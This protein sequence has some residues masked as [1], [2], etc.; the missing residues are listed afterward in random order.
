MKIR[1]QIKNLALSELG[2]LNDLAEEPY[3]FRDEAARER[4]KEQILLS[5]ANDDGAVLDELIE[6]GFR[7]ADRVMTSASAET[8]KARIVGQGELLPYN[9]SQPLVLGE[10]ER[11]PFG[12]ARYEHLQRNLRVETENNIAQNAAFKEKYQVRTQFSDALRTLDPRTRVEDIV[13]I[14]GEDA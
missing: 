2:I 12:K 13:E 14:E 8:L 6:A 11:I 10:G 9:E 1:T 3:D 5:L 7:D 4:V